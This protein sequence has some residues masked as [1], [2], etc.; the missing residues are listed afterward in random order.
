[1]TPAMLRDMQRR[2]EEKY[3]N[4]VNSFEMSYSMISIEMSDQILYSYA[5]TQL[6]YSVEPTRL[7]TW[8]RQAVNYM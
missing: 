4:D 3:G 6:E 8:P 1:M 2:L 7:F 5:A